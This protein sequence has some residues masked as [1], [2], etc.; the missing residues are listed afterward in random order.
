MRARAD[1]PGHVVYN[2]VR[3]ATE[4]LERKFQSS[5]VVIDA[6]TLCQLHRQCLPDGGNPVGHQDGQSSRCYSGSSRSDDSHVSSRWFL[7][8][9]VGW[10]GGT[11]LGDWDK[12]EANAGGRVRR[13]DLKGLGLQGTLPRSLA[14][15]AELEYLDLRHNPD[16]L[17]I[18]GAPLDSMG[19][20]CYHT[21][22]QVQTFLRHLAL[23]DRGRELALRRRQLVQKHGPEGPALRAIFD[24]GNGREWKTG[25][26]GQWFAVRN[27]D[28]ASWYG[29][30]LDQDKRVVALSLRSTR[31]VM[32][33]EGISNLASLAKL[34]MDGC[35]SLTSLLESLGN[36]ASL[37]NLDLN[38]CKCLL[39]TGQP[40]IR[41]L[42][43]RGVNVVGVELV[44]KGC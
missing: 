36:L 37:T 40:V 18:I 23:D 21:E 1:L 20:M 43:A 8:E 15:L 27:S 3:V 29:V 14:A 13:L 5:A 19:Q 34:D 4:L 17:P 35:S 2:P 32:L 7:L 30:T 22:M 31:I 42:A 9:D 12:V 10:L 25:G 6:L 33:S 39:V 44:D 26:K 11:A 38:G 41:K 16:L 24:E 28:P